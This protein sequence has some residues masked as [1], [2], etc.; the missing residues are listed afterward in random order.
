MDNKEFIPIYQSIQLMKANDALAQLN[1]AAAAQARQKAAAKSAQDRV[2]A[3]NEEFKLIQKNIECYPLWSVLRLLALHADLNG[4]FI[5]SWL[6]DL[7][8]AVP[9]DSMTFPLKAQ[10]FGPVEQAD[11]ELLDFKKLLSDTNSGI[12]ESLDQWQKKNSEAVVKQLMLTFQYLTITST[13]EATA[14]LLNYDRQQVQ[15]K[16]S[17]FFAFL[18]AV[19]VGMVC[20]IVFLCATES[21]ASILGILFIELFFMALGVIPSLLFR[22]KQNK[23]SRALKIEIDALHA[24]A[25]DYKQKAVEI[26]Q[27]LSS[28]GS[29]RTPESVTEDSV[30]SSSPK[31]LRLESGSIH[32]ACGY[33]KQPM[34]IDASGGGM[35]IKCPECGEP[36]KVPTS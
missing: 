15:P 25:K 21:K 18:G 30:K 35:E 13:K 24:E 8:D 16:S 33:C 32:F 22:R 6:E 10:S 5:Y 9:G 26:I 28:I 29:N 4:R 2:F 3:A 36:Q 23:K 27:S 31:F 11:L 7:K 12:Q 1:N 34:E 14:T 20:G 19:F 17:E